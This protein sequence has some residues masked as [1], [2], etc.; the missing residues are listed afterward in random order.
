MHYKAKKKLHEE[1]FLLSA[2]SSLPH[3]FALV[4]ALMPM[5][6][7]FAFGLVDTVMRV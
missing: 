1:E 5:V 4:A 6:V 2:C 7:R 3:R